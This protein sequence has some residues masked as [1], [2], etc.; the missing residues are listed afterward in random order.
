MLHP[1][2]LLLAQDGLPS[3]VPRLLLIAILQLLRPFR[4]VQLLR[5]RLLLLSQDVDEVLQRCRFLSCGCADQEHGRVLLLVVESLF[6]LQALMA[7]FELKGQS[8]RVL[9]LGRLL[10]LGQTRACLITRSQIG[11]AD[12]VLSTVAAPACGDVGRC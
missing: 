6:D 11:R 9:Q 7:L 1:K 2:C 5:V 8:D 10:L 4:S 12:R 3:L